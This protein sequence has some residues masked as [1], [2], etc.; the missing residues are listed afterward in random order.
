MQSADKWQAGCWQPRTL[1]LVGSVYG[2][3]SNWFLGIGPQGI[4]LVGMLLNFIVTLS[5][6]PLTRA[7][8]PSV[9][10]MIDSIHEP[11]AALPTVVLEAAPPPC[12]K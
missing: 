11:E 8:S 3:M 12:V 10:E 1:P 7:P 4:G 9:R 5:L 2:G 6:T